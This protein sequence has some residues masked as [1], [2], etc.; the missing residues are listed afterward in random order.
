MRGGGHEM[1]CIRTNNH[2][3]FQSLM[4]E[5]Q[6][7]APWFQC[8]SL[9]SGI[10]LVEMLM[11]V[12]MEM[13]SGQVQILVV[14]DIDLISAA[15]ISEKYVCGESRVM[16]DACIICGPFTHRSI[17]S[18]EDEAIAI[19]DMASIIAQFENIVC[20]VVYIAGD[21]DPIRTLS[22]QLCLTPNSV[23]IH[24]RSLPLINGLYLS[25]FTEKD[26]VLSVYSSGD[27]DSDDETDGYEI[28]TSSSVKIIDEVLT[29]APAYAYPDHTS[30][31][32]PQGIFVLNYKYPHT[33]NHFLF[34]Q[35]D[36]LQSARIKLAVIPSPTSSEEEEEGQDER[37]RNEVILPRHLRGLTIVSPQSLRLRGG[38][39]VVTLAMVGGEGQGWEVTEVVDLT[40]DE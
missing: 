35:T 7:I 18:P 24:A 34:F 1:T 15:K 6:L 2:I 12:E 3:F 4:I 25:G 40:L 37:R 13:T 21:N 17:T 11:C 36:V 39:S 16:F 30:P 32:P 5:F 28:Q 10:E 9:I 22:D 33:L 29:N 38:Y 23:N 26:S 8:H 31:F 19:G 14:H 20:R 27:D